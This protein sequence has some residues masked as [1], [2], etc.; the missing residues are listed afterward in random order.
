MRWLPL[1]L[2]LAQIPLYA[3]YLTDD[4]YIYAQF[5]RNLAQGELAFNRGEVVHAATSPLWAGLGAI[6]ER[7]AMPA[8]WFLKVLG[9]LCGAA[10]V[11]FFTAALR[12]ACRHRAAWL[13]GGLAFAVQPWF[14]RWSA[15]AME[16]AAAAFCVAFLLW[17]LYGTSLQSS[18]RALALV[19]G[20]GPLLRPELTLLVLLLALAA[21]REPSLRRRPS[22]F[23]LLC[24][25]GLLWVALAKATGL[26][27]L[28]TT[29]FAK[30]TGAGLAADRLLPN[31]RVLV[32]IVGV[33]AALPLAWW[34]FTWRRHRS[35]LFGWAAPALWAW[36]VLLPAIYLWRDVQV[37]S[38]YLEIWVPIPLLAAFL[39]AE[40]LPRWWP[41]L[42]WLHLSLCLGLS[43]VWIAPSTRAFSRSIDVA[44]N[45]FSAWLREHTP[46]DCEVAAYDIGLLGYRSQR[47]IFDLGGLVDARIARLRRQL[48]DETIVRSG[49]FLE[50]GRP[51]YLLHRAASADALADLRWGELRPLPIRSQRVANL[52]VSRADEVVYTLYRLEAVAN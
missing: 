50:F 7:L 6:A 38:R 10:A 29:M 26:S 42:A 3:N 17:C 41:S 28:P 9:W 47:R 12:G 23:L 32:Q 31:L 45:E 21:L 11:C 13:L 16:T 2:Y 51:D 40:R 35:A 46:G 52:G 20:I 43:V 5:A 44:M 14:V 24:L 49:R 18:W 30:S 25:P 34:G 1:L 4:S 48:D 36:V 15:S 22:F 27:V 39:A 37:V 33:A 19:S 8:F